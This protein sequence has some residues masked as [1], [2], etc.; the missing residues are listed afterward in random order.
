MSNLLACSMAVHFLFYTEIF[1]SVGVYEIPVFMILDEVINFTCPCI[2]KI[3]DNQLALGGVL[4]TS[5]SAKHRLVLCFY[6]RQG[7]LLLLTLSNCVAARKASPFVIQCLYTLY[8]T[9]GNVTGQHGKHFLVSRQTMH[10][11]A[12]SSNAV[13]LTMPGFNSLACGGIVILPGNNAATERGKQV[14]LCKGMPV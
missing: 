9:L 13:L 10:L 11:M 7:S 8:N 14:I 12:Y 4:Y 6:T 5:C 1:E 3:I 2:L